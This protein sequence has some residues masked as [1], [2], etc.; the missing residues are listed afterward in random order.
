MT[1]GFKQ[2]PPT[3]RV[4]LFYA[5]IDNSRANSGVF[6]QRALIV[7]QKLAAG[8]AAANVPAISQ[9]VADAKSAFGQG[10]DLARMV[11]AYRQN[12][13]FGELWCLPL[14][15]DA[16]GT[17]ATGSVAL[18]GPATGNGML[19]LYV[20]GVKVQQGVASGQTAAQIATALAATINANN[21]LPVTAVASTGTVNL[22]AKHK[23]PTGNEID[24]RVNYLGAIGGETLP[25]GVGATITA[26]TGGAT[27]PSLATALAN[28]GD[29]PFDFIVFPFTDTSS[30]DALKGLLDD[31]TGR[32][33]WSRQIYGHGFAA[34]AGTLSGLTTFGTARNDQ[35]V[36]V[37]GFNDSPTPAHIWAA[38]VGGAAAAS[39]R[40]DP[41]LPLQTVVLKGVLAP[42]IP[43]RFPLT[44]RNTLLFDGVSTFTV[45]DD[46]TVRIE[47]LITTYQKNGFGMPDD[48]YLEIETLFTLAFMLRFYRS[49]ITSKFAR[50]KLAADGTR[51]PAGSNIVTPKII[52]A[53][54]YA[55]GVELE[56]LGIV[57]GVSTW[58]PQI[59]VEKNA[60]NP[61]RVDVL[62]PAAL[63][64]QLRIFA[65]L[66]Q[67][68][69]TV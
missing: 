37:M 58:G 68:R 49:R 47:N 45:D 60:L 57:Q 33:A 14:S 36:S 41:A 15:D 52:K 22:T 10:S 65:V 66:A 64:N 53:E 27:V 34:K 5:E 51:F 16:G 35:H 67:F 3:V 54:M 59:I 61:N 30:L 21:D 2:L 69:L 43:S 28:L 56:S 32:W 46:G 50:T 23:G 44:D 39:L 55:A 11:D 63:I 20:G 18:T 42:P 7:G 25:A 12:D 8:S 13:S 38:A 31:I 26:M 17:A 24:L 4:P 6:S 19:A 62:L 9:G 1:I 29:L 40:V 48:S